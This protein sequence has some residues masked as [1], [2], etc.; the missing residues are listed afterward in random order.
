[1]DVDK[2]QARRQLAPSRATTAAETTSGT[3]VRI[4]VSLLADQSPAVQALV[5]LQRVEQEVPHRIPVPFSLPIG[6]DLLDRFLGARRT[7]PSLDQLPEF[8]DGVGDGR[9]G[10]PLRQPVRCFPHEGQRGIRQLW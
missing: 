9:A 1:M 5:F 7:E 2:A 4:M 10:A 8:L 3:A 6:C